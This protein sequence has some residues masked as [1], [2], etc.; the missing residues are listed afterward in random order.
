MW[1][2]PPLE[3]P[4][5]RMEPKEQLDQKYVV[6]SFRQSTMDGQEQEAAQTGCVPAFL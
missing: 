6:F 1:G 3:Q 5:E 2:F 4:E